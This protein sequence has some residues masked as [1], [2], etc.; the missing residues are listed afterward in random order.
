MARPGDELAAGSAG[1]GHLRASHA[2]REQVI[3]TLKAAFVAGMLAKDEFDLRVGKTLASRTYAQLAALTADL[4]AGLT[5][6]QPRPPAR[7]QG[8]VRIPRPGRL[9]MVATV[10]YAGMWP[11]AM[12]L[13]VDSEGEPHAGLNLVML[14]GLAYLV[15]LLL[16][17]TQISMDWQ[18]KRAARRPPKGHAS[19]AGGPAAPRP[20]STRPGQQLPPAGHGHWHAAVVA[21]RRLGRSA[22]PVSGHCAGGALAA[23]TTPASG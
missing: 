8:E 2:D 3:G 9:L 22:W 12:L 11:L 20:P 13:P 6:A 5:T 10:V 18:D 23:G 15:V 14:T 16:T 21:R 7:A 1:R 17:L 19:G 4:P